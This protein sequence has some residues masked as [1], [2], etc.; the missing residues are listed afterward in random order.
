MKKILI[1]YGDSKYRKAQGLNTWTGYHIAGFDEVRSFGPQDISEKYKQ[2]HMDIFSEKRGNGLWLW[3]P[4]IIDKVLNECNEG[5]FVFYLDSG[6][7]FLK[8]IDKI[9]N[10]MGKED[11]IY[12]SDV[13]LL[14]G[15]FTKSAC[16]DYL[17]CNTADMKK[18]NQ[19]QGG[20]VGLFCCEY[21]KAFVRQWKELCEQYD[22]LSPDGIIPPKEYK[23]ESYVA[24]RE[25]QSILSLL[26]KQKGISAHREPSQRGGRFQDSYY[27]PLYAYKPTKHADQYGTV[28]F[29]HKSPNVNVMRIIA[30]TLRMMFNHYF[31]YRKIA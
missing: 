28:V 15:C 21:T 11:K 16:F 22:L 23:G 3:K 12:V 2:E 20:Y 17:E 27:S 7:F 26:C 14:E 13:P 6:A 18:T 5:D 31:K 9:I 4:Y 1:N 30:N 24:H 25:D 8:P 29:L 10:S 19:I